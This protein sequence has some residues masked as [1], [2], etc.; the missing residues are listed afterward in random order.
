VRENMFSMMDL[1]NCGSD[2][3]YEA[4]TMP[5]SSPAKGL[6]LRHLSRRGQALADLWRQNLPGQ[7]NAKRLA[8]RSIEVASASPAR[9]I[10][11]SGVLPLVG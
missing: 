1:S 8:L 2:V 5:G 9:T 7:P 6:K 10:S 3:Q 11:S 4:S